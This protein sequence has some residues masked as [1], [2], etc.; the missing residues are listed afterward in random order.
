MVQ[1]VGLQASCSLHGTVF[2]RLALTVAVAV[3]GQHALEGLVLAEHLVGVG[4]DDL[5]HDQHCPK[6]LGWCGDCIL[7]CIYVVANVQIQLMYTLAS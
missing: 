1:D 7:V 3:L 6:T 2:S 5:C 4:G